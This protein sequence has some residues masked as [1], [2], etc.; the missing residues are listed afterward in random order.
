MVKEN[1][2]LS[3]RLLYIVI[4]EWKH[5]H[6]RPLWFL[7]IKTLWLFFWGFFGYRCCIRNNRKKVN[8]ICFQANFLVNLILNLTS[9][10]R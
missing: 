8:L 3:N 6:V 10:V 1:I 5:L 7:V 2:T 4:Y 9:R